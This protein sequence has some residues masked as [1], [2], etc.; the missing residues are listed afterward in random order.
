MAVRLVEIAIER[1]TL[2]NERFPEEVGLMVFSELRHHLAFVEM[3]PAVGVLV[4][5]E[6]IVA[7]SRQGY[8]RVAHDLGRKSIRAVIDPESDEDAVRVL[9]AD[10]GVEFL[11]WEEIDALEGA[12]PVADVWH[13]F[14]FERP[15][16]PLEK[17]QFERHIVGFFSNRALFPDYERLSRPA[18]V[19][20]DDSASRVDFRV[21]T[22][23]GDDRWY[24]SWLAILRRFSRGV[25]EIMTYQ[26]MRF[27]P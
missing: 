25:V 6:V 18:D 9:R 2:D 19:R 10:A 12:T 21:P 3:L 26:G 5:P 16:T 7:K 4:E 1:V 15:L 23:V 17:E 22:P 8:L 13:S 14:S 27:G 24:G 11:D 20:Y